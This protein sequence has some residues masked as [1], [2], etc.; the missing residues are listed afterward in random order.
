MLSDFVIQKYGDLLYKTYQDIYIFPPYLPRF[1]KRSPPW[2]RKDAFRWLFFPR[3]FVYDH[4]LQKK[5]WVLFAVC[6]QHHKIILLN[7]VAKCYP[8]TNELREIKSFLFTQKEQGFLVLPEDNFQ[9][10]IKQVPQQRNSIDC[11]IFVLEFI[12]RLTR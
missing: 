5:H 6:P 7:S 8:P 10:E 4:C 2:S 3:I 12:V 11:G 1:V 9:F